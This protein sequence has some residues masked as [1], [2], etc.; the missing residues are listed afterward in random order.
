MITLYD[1]KDCC[2]CSACV[3]SCPKHC[4]TLHEDS[5]GFLYP[6]VDS[7]ACI[8]CGLC[9]KVCPVIHPSAARTPLHVYAAINPDEHIRM[10]SSSGGIF[11]L[12]AEQI[13]H[14]GGVVFGARFDEHWEVRHDYTETPEGLAAFRGSKYLQSRMGDT[15][16]TVRKF[17]NDHRKVLFTGTPCQ[18][19]GL[20]QYLHKP[21]D[22][23]LTMECLCFGV[24][25]PLVWRKYLA[26]KSPRHTVSHVNFRDK[27]TGWIG[28]HLQIQY[29]S[30][31]ESSEAVSQNAFMQGFINKLY[32]RPS[33]HQCPAKHG[34]S[35]SDITVG[36]YWNI[37]NVHPELNAGNKGV[38]LVLLNTPKGETF[39][40]KIVTDSV[41]TT[42]DEA[43]QI[44]N[45][46]NESYE[47]HPRRTRFFLQ[48]AKAPS[49]EALI[50][51]CLKPTCK[52]R[53]QQVLQTIKEII[54]YK[55]KQ[56]KILK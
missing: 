52:T 12:L 4:I 42:Y 28:Y 23:L 38:A 16:Q 5:E 26:E 19:A 49:V 43:R 1:K 40:K 18:I 41:E 6:S 53:I 54:R 44:N 17:L 51:R 11:T 13:L 56:Y 50:R 2:G 30:R 8:D 45:G 27:T 34:K 22:N 31:T 48:L 14:E 3:S 7:S 15:Y 39:Y 21:Y 29:T 25:S 24:P 55:L 46:F 32:V 33:C 35:G 47:P 10:K 20:Y 36:D 37:M 9:E